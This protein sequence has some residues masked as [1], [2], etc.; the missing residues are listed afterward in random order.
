[1]PGNVASAAGPRG[2]QTSDCV[3]LVSELV[4]KLASRNEPALATM[5][6]SP[7]VL[8]KLCL[9][10]CSG[11]GLGEGWCYLGG[12][13]GQC[14]SAA[15]RVRRPRHLQGAMRS[16]EQEQGLSL[17]SKFQRTGRYDQNCDLWNWEKARD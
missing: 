13:R 8:R 2:P 16:Q 10:E 6:W 3:G 5:A 9:G 11:H 7:G 12:R 1:M 4:S 17:F 15:H 14:V